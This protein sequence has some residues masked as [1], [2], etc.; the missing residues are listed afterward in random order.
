M[1]NIHRQII[2]LRAL[3]R[4]STKRHG[5]PILSRDLTPFPSCYTHTYAHVHAT[6]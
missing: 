3:T 4:V 6:P 2:D 1:S 5:F